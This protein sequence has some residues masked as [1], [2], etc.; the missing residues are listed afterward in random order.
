M[1]D[2]I[3]DLGRKVK[4]KYPEY[5]DMSDEEVGR[6]VKAKFPGEYDDFIDV[7]G[8]PGTLERVGK[9]WDT[10]S[11]APAGDWPGFGPQFRQQLV[12]AF[13]GMAGI[14]P[15]ANAAL[16]RTGSAML[17]RDPV[18]TAFQAAGIVPIIGPQTQQ[19][20]QDVAAG[21]NPEALGHFLRLGTQLA[22]PKAISKAPAAMEAGAR[23]VQRGGAVAAG[24]ARG[25]WDESMAPGVI[26]KAGLKIPVPQI[27]ETTFGG[28]AAGRT[29]GHTGLGA[30]VGAA[31]PIIKGAI[32]G[33]RKANRAFKA[34]G[35]PPP[36]SGPSLVGVTKDYNPVAG[37]GPLVNVQNPPVPAD[38]NPVVGEGPLVGIPQPPE[39]IPYSPVVGEG[40]IVQVPNAPPPMGQSRTS[41]TGTGMPPKPALT[42]APGAPGGEPLAGN[43]SVATSIL[44]ERVRAANAA[45]D[46]RLA[47]VSHSDLV[48]QIHI[49][50]QEMELP[51]SPAGQRVKTG[52]VGGIAMEIYG[53]GWSDLTKAQK[54]TLNE[55]VQ[56]NRRVPTKADIANGTYV[57][58]MPPPREP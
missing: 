11:L 7:A 25:A 8:K 10:P 13:Q 18:D 14:V 2:T 27:A 49:A 58:Y 17:R 54:H 55:F 3:I 21:N 57:E 36:P 50:L 41:G 15:Q 48:K 30:A 42:P 39:P 1:A 20:G 23:G 4:A 32:Q 34:K 40:P 24:A 52:T 56:E 28:A 37:E 43:E 53:K 51:G 31:A 26:N 12:D 45:R 5:N 19:I 16:Q 38:Y 47:E 9:A 35:M 44:M 29:L 46:R 6:K 22:G 33:G